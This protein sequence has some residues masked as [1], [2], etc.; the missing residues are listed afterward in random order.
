[1]ISAHAPAVV[2]PQTGD[3]GAGADGLSEEKLPNA[4][5]PALPRSAA[6]QLGEVLARLWVIRPVQAHLRRTRCTGAL[7]RSVLRQSG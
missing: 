6:Q 3:G 5:T 1:M 7:D 4:I 2:D